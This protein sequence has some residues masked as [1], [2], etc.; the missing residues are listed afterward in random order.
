M[1]GKWRSFLGTR[2][3]RRERILSR[4]NLEASIRMRDERRVPTFSASEVSFDPSACPAS[5][6]FRDAGLGDGP[7]R[8]N[9][10]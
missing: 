9:G 6:D 2:I 3:G 1:I 10:R 5:R 8:N 7:N 4:K